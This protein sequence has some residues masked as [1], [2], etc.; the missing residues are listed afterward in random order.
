MLSLEYKHFIRSDT[1]MF[2]FIDFYANLD[3]ETMVRLEN[4]Q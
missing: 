3:E 2:L 1:G 4:G